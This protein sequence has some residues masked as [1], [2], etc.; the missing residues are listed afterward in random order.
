MSEA[1]EQDDARRKYEFKKM[2]ERL[3]AKEGSGTE[4]ISL[5]IPPDK[6]IYDVTAQLRDE[7]GPCS[8]LKSKQK[9]TNV[10]SAIYSLLSR[11][12]YYSKQPETG[13]ADFC[14]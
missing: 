8:N 11:L 2:L 1:V 12:N 4:L 13:I 9:R 10:Q 5:Y 14:G 7:F 6:Q 3:E